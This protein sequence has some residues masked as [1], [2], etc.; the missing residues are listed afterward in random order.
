MG[1]NRLDAKRALVLEQANSISTAFLRSELLPEPQRSQ[2]QVLL[3]GYVDQILSVDQMK[4]K[5]G[6]YSAGQDF[7]EQA[8]LG[9]QKAKKIE[10]ELWQVAVAATNLNPTPGTALFVGS[11]NQMIDLLQT[12]FTTSFQERMLP[13]FWVI[14]FGLA[15]LAT[16]LVGYDMGVSRSQRSFATWVVAV[17][18]SAVMFLVIALDRPQSSTITDLPLRELKAELESARS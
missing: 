1:T 15:T 16:G 18:F 10:A 3:S 11:I 2:T 14:L 4:Q 6:R 5:Y 13:I 9:L 8:F 17:A 7:A 12:R